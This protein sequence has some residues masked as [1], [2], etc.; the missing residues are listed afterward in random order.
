MRDQP[1]DEGN[2]GRTRTRQ[3]RTLLSVRRCCAL[4]SG[5]LRGL[6]I[7]PSRQP[8]IGTL[9]RDGTAPSSSTATASPLSA[10][11]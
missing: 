1:L 2:Q 5:G 7:R 8:A 6:V 3:R 4:C 10:S 11:T 9:L